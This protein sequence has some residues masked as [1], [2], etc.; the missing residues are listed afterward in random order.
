MTKAACSGTCSET[1][2]QNKHE[3]K[4]ERL[5]FKIISSDDILIKEVIEQYNSI[6]KTDFQIERFLYDE[7]VFAIISVDKLTDISNIFHLG[8]QFGAFAQ[9][10]RNNKEIDW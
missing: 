6:Y 3:P 8:Y 1:F 9:Y 7:V 10:K 5:T 4:M 2:I